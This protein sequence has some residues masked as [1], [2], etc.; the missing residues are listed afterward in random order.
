MLCSHSGKKKIIIGNFRIVL[1][2]VLYDDFFITVFI[3][4][5]LNVLLKRSAIV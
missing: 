4:L 3:T 5:L 1:I 2:G